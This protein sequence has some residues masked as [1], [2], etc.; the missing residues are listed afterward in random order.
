MT[1][2]CEQS[3]ARRQKL[4]ESA[5]D[6]NGM[7]V[8]LN[9]I[10]YAVTKPGEIE[11]HLF[12]DVDTQLAVGFPREKPQGRVLDKRQFFIRDIRRSAA[13]E[14]QQATVCATRQNVIRLKVTPR[15]NTPYQLE[16]VALDV[17]GARLRCAASWIDPRNNSVDIVF[18]EQTSSSCAGAQAHQSDSP[19]GSR[20]TEV[21]P[22][23]PKLPPEPTRPDP[24]IN[25]LARDYA[26]FRQLILDRL[27]QIMPGWQ[28]R[29]AADLGITLVEMLAYAG[30]RLSYYQDAVATEAYLETAPANF[31]T[32]S[33]PTD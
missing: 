7:E 4:Q 29:H 3:S 25:Y 32:P 18:Y 5:V 15:H 12:R 10:D 20:V 1:L 13:L 2:Q 14:V 11:L 17:H 21:D 30:D 33:R 6:V 9:G 28:E 16:I 23:P 22:L 26:S 24:D 8:R 27:A 19:R 31:R